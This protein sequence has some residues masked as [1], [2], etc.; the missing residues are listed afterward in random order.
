MNGKTPERRKNIVLADNEAAER[1]LFQIILDESKLE[2]NLTMLSTGD[3]LLE[4][5]RT[6][7]ALPD[8][9]FLDIDMPLKNGIQTLA[10]IRSDHR[11]NKIPVIM[12]TNN[13][14]EKT[15]DAAWYNRAD[16]YVIKP[17]DIKQIQLIFEWLLANHTT[18]K[19]VRRN[20]F[21][22][23]SLDALMD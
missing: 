12:Y 10:E 11:L 17:S 7:E 21:V 2:V 1:R 5:L 9:I 3:K 18:H 19:Q 13:L 16:Y 15:I 14:N 8:I 23:N 4:M 20:R 6:T 22:I